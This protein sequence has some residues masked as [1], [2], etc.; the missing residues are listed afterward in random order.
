MRTLFE[1]LKLLGTTFLAIG[2][3]QQSQVKKPLTP[4]IR[5]LAWVGLIAVVG[6]L[7]YPGN[8]KL[9][10][11]MNDGDEA[12]ALELIKA[13]A[14]PNSTYG[15]SSIENQKAPASPLHFALSR[16]QPK[17]AVA[18]IQAGADPNSRDHLGNTALIVAAN[19]GYTEVVRALLAKGANPRAANTSDGET[20]LR[21]GP[22]GPGGRYPGLGYYPKS[23][24]PEIKE[25]L[26]KSGAK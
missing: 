11:A 19:A 17:I 21:D 18:L 9:Y 8:S 25:M 2:R 14:D 26:V 24:K 4:A 6:F 3:L 1:T 7:V 10:E 15:R 20:P 13:G 16:G 5:V 22:K 23:L 12:R